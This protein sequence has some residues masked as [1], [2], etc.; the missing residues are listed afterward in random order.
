VKLRFVGLAVLRATAFFL[1]WLLLVDS[2]G[3]QQLVAGGIC[4]VIAAALATGIHSRGSVG[5]RLRPSMLRFVYR[6]LTLLVSDSARVT[7][8]LFARVVL[9][10]TVSGRIRAVRYDAVADDPEDVTR[11]ILTEWGASAAPNRYAIGI[12][13]DRRVLVVHELVRSS[14]PLDPLELG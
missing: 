13:P 9:R 4:A 10:R 14:G 7:W 12:D 5:A 8:A 1:L 2:V 3:E 6:P 11:R